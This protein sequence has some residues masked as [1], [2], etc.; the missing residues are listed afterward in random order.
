MIAH[1]FRYPFA[2]LAGAGMFLLAIV[3]SPGLMELGAATYDRVHP[4]TSDWI[5]T[6]S[7]VDGADIVLSGTMLKNRN[8]VF[9]PP[10]V[11]RDSAGQ[12]YPV[13]SSSPTAGKTWAASGQPQRFGPW[14]VVGGAGKRLTFIN[15]YVCG[16][17]RPSILELGVYGQDK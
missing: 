15:V 10:T 14:R 17:G 12:N 8:C 11:A 3:M 16:E 7:H 6:E 1:A 9:V 2:I 4:I 13:V 5:I